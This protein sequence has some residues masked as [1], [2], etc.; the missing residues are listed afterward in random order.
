MSVPALRFSK[1]P[2]VS[3]LSRADLL[4]IQDASLRVLSNVGVHIEHQNTLNL[5][6]ESGVTIDRNSSRV[7]FPSKLIHDCLARIPRSFNLAGYA[8]EDDLLISQDSPLYARPGIGMDSILDY[9]SGVRREAKSNDL[10]EWVRAIQ[11]LENLHIVA[12]IYPRDI[13]DQLR[14]VQAIESSLRFSKKPV[15]ICAYS[16]QSLYWMAMLVSALPRG[17]LPRIL[18]VVSADSPLSFSDNQIEIMLAAARHEFPIILNSASLIGATCPVTMFGCLI[19]MNA[20][21]LA[22]LT[23]LQLAYPGTPCIY[24]MQPLIFDMR[25]GSAAFGY[26]EL[27]LLNCAFVELGRSYGLPTEGSGLKTD[28]HRC[29]VQA[30]IEKISTVYLTMFSGANIIS[31]AGCLSTAATASLPQLVIDNDII[32][33]LLQ[34]A[35]GIRQENLEAAMDAIA[36][37]GPGGHYLADDHTLKNFRTE[38]FISKLPVRGTWESWQSSGE[39]SEIELANDYLD[40]LLEK[41]KEPVIPTEIGNEFTRIMEEAKRELSR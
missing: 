25:F 34:V 9:R 7:R 23:I 6:R 21:A 2:A 28:S 15:V 14:D 1:Q 18:V 29:D 31:G 26:A 16:A 30:G 11:G 12:P 36:R 5:L 19:Q 24:D 13:P 22:G 4:G 39:K 8:Q 10:I 32:A 27:G 37:V 38:Y 35:N 3:V 20:E 41:H 40:T 17:P 33:Q